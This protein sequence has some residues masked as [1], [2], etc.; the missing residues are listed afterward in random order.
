MLGTYIGH[1]KNNTKSIGYNYSL[2]LQKD[3]ICRLNKTHDIYNVIGIGKWYII[4]KIIIIEYKKNNSDS[5][6]D[7]L[8]AGGYLEG[9]DTFS[10]LNINT[11]RIGT[12]VLKKP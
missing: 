8:R 7:A 12:A 10:I 4:D 11:I 3:S 9:K 5:L 2:E 6:E 1:D